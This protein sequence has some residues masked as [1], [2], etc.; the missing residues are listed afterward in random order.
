MEKV[1]GN[2]YSIFYIVYLGLSSIGKANKV[3]NK[4]VL[5]VKDFFRQVNAYALMWPM[6]SI[7]LI[8]KQLSLLELILV[9][10]NLM[11]V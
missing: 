7:W 5:K 1:S 11:L 8:G 4:W 9:C 10:L 6:N 3:T 2:I